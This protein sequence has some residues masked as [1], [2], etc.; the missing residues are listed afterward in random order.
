MQLKIKQKLGAMTEILKNDYKTF[1]AEVKERIRQ[2]KYNVQNC[3][4]WLQKLAGLI[5]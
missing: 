3:N 4:H 5:T 2:A 1:L